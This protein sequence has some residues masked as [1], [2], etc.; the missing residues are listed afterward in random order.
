MRAQSCWKATILWPEEST[1]NLS[2]LNTDTDYSIC[3]CMWLCVYVCEWKGERGLYPI[4]IECCLL[5]KPVTLWLQNIYSYLLPQI[6]A[7]LVLSTKHPP[8]RKYLI[9][10]LYDCLR[11]LTL[12][13][14]LSNRC[15][16]MSQQ[17][18]NTHI[19]Q[20]R[21]SRSHFWGYSVHHEV[22]KKR[23]NL[24]WPGTIVN[25]CSM[26]RWQFYN[27]TPNHLKIY[28]YVLALAS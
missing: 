12:S 14:H 21:H 23:M 24:V 27:T 8:F 25:T 5:P 17:N 9:R 26:G 11:F 18:I 10:R 7:L 13:H 16:Q 19:Y 4:Y 15:P 28:L 6:S 22:L 2:I 20:L 3:I 1:A